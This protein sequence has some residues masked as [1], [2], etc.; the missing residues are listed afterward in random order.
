MFPFILPRNESEQD[1]SQKR[2]PNLPSYG[3]FI[4]SHEVGKLERLFDF[5]EE[6]LYRPTRLI[7]IAN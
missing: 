1:V 3:V 4:V 7:E 5:L 2:R 6:N